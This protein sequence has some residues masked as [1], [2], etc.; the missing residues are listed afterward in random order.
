MEVNLFPTGT[1]IVQSV[2][3]LCCNRLNP[4]CYNVGMGPIGP[5]HPIPPGTRTPPPRLG[6]QTLPRPRRQGRG[7]PLP[8]HRLP[9]AKRP[10]CPPPPD[11]PP[12]PNHPIFF[13][14]RN[15]YFTKYKES[16]TIINFNYSCILFE[17]L[18]WFI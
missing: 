7:W 11:R 9:R 13:F 4:M 17:I 10:S 12:T 15:W 2:S 8:R 1:K 18:G 6:P 16:L 14:S 5:I 3:D